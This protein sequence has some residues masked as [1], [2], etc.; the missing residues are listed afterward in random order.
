MLIGFYQVENTKSETL[1]NSFKDALDRIDVLL[2]NYKAQC[3]DGTYNIVCAK[4][5]V[6][7]CINEIESRAHLTHCH[8]RAFHLAIGDIIKAIKIMRGTLAQYLN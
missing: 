2:T 6:A 7:T 5:R 4:T 1:V 3:Y 8:G